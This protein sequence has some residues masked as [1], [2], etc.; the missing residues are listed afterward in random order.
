MQAEHSTMQITGKNKCYHIYKT[1]LYYTYSYI[2]QFMIIIVHMSNSVYS[3]STYL[4]ALRYI[5]SYVHT[6]CLNTW[7]VCGSY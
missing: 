1:N 3:I 7:D 4:W 2:Y 5:Q 6:H